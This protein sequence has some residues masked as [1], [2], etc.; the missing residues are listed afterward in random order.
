MKSLEKLSEKL[1]ER[2]SPEKKTEFISKENL[3]K[4]FDDVVI[5]SFENIKSEL[6]KHKIEA[7]I[8]KFVYKARLTVNEHSYQFLFTIECNHLNEIEIKS[9]IKLQKLSNVISF[10]SSHSFDE[11]EVADYKTM[12]QENI[13]EWFTERF[14][15]KEQ[16]FARKDKEDRDW[17]KDISEFQKREINLTEDEYQET[18]LQIRKIE[19]QLGQNDN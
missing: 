13:V 6:K 7:K 2:Y 19:N 18:L 8:K 1:S 4:F 9:D 5:P 17:Y 10:S 12:N 16:E 14:L 11:I 3:A 15:T